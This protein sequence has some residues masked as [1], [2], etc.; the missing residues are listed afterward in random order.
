MIYIY[1][2]NHI[3]FF[4]CIYIYV[5]LYIIIQNTVIYSIIISKI[6]ISDQL[7]RTFSA[8]PWLCPGPPAI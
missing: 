7:P 8:A 1:I 4:T 2:Y 5:Y 3:S 6:A